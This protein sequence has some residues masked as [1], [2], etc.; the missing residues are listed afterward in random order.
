MN[1]ALYHLCFTND[2]CE[3]ELIS[4]HATREVAWEVWKAQKSTMTHI[5]IMC[6]AELERQVRYSTNEQDGIRHR[7]SRKRKQRKECQRERAL[8]R[9]L[10]GE[11]PEEAY[12]PLTAKFIE[13]TDFI[14]K[15]EQYI[16]NG[17]RRIKRCRYMI[18]IYKTDLE[19]LRAALSLEVAVNKEAIDIMEKRSLAYTSSIRGDDKPGDDSEID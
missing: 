14:D 1:D 10:L 5:R 19:L 15:G 11:L 16:E 8:L 18:D 2:E 9:R 17:F 3:L 13:L 6:I 12:L 7:I 4:S